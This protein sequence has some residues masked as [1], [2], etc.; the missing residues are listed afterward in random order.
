MTLSDL[1]K[2]LTEL[3]K[4]LPA[5]APVYLGTAFGNTEHFFTDFDVRTLSN[6][7]IIGLIPSDRWSKNDYKLSEKR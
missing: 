2:Q 6:G 5:T 3:R 1:I 7:K 4:Q